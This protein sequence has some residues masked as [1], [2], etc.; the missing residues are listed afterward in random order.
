M[1]LVIISGRGGY[2]S[3]INVIYH[4]ILSLEFKIQYLLAYLSIVFNDEEKEGSILKALEKAAKSDLRKIT[5]H[6]NKEK[7]AKIH[8]DDI[9]GAKTE[10]R[11]NPKENDQGN[12]S[13]S[14]NT[15]TPKPPKQQSYFKRIMQEMKVQNK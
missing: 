1:C 11:E 8:N 15:D 5:D 9:D 2:K 3:V 6:E 10:S 4:D 14:L 12:T 7:P 13:E